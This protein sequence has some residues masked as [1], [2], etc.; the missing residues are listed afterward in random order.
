MAADPSSVA[1]SWAR[2]NLVLH[3]ERRAAIQGAISEL[4]DRLDSQQGLDDGRLHRLI[5]LSSSLLAP[6]RRLPREVLSEIFLQSSLHDSVP[7]SRKFAHFGGRG[8]NAILA[9]SHH[10]RATILYTAKFWSEFNIN[11]PVSALHQDL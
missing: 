5:A 10:W 2:E 7:R 3:E 8:T 9:V 1:L 11:L 4:Q 6:I